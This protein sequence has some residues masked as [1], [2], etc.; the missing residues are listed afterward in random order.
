MAGADYLHC[1]GCGCKVAY[2]AET[3]YHNLGAIWAYC[4]K[5]AERVTPPVL[6][7]PVEDGETDG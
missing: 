4:P 2:D 3:D 6:V 5:C 1:N 7:N